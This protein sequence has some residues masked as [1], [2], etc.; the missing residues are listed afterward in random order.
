MSQGGWYEKK[1]RSHS[2]GYVK[3]GISINPEEKNGILNNNIFPAN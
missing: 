3:H 1:W 2:T